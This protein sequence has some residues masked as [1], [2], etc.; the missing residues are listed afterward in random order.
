MAVAMAGVVPTRVRVRRLHRGVGREEIKESAPVVLRD[1]GA[2]I[3][4]HVPED[5]ARQITATI[6][7]LALQR[8][9][10]RRCANVPRPAPQRHQR[11]AALALRIRHRK[12]CTCPA[13]GVVFYFAAKAHV[14]HLRRSANAL[15]LA[16]I[17]LAHWRRQAAHPIATVAHEP[18][19]C[20]ARTL[21]ALALVV[22]RDYAIAHPALCAKANRERRNPLLHCALRRLHARAH[23]L[24]S[25]HV[26]SS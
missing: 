14:V 1:G 16:A 24:V 18:R 5:S 15:K 2:E 7:I 20:V 22:P 12:V 10:Q 3:D 4:E 13:R 17:R 11:G 21:C 8:A 6:A 19:Q 25:R 26:A 23:L 9:L